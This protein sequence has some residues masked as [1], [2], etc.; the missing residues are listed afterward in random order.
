M[1]KQY[2]NIRTHYSSLSL[3]QV[4]LLKIAF[5]ICAIFASA[6]ISIPLKPIPVTFQSAMVLLIGFLYPPKQSFLT[7]MLYIIFGIVGLPIF[8]KFSHG[9]NYLGGMTAGYLIG[10][11]ISAP[12]IG[13]LWSKMNDSWCSVFFISTLAHT[14]IFFSGFCW[15]ANLIGVYSAIYSGFLVLIPTGLLKVVLFTYLFSIL[16]AFR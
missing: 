5:G 6:Q 10:M 8:A 9:I 11:L 7:V 1:K 15:L 16:K 4:Q 12:I 14:I 2:E 13:M 3:N